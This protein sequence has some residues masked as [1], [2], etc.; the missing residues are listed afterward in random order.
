MLEFL[1]HMQLPADSAI[2]RLSLFW[3]TAH[4]T[5]ADSVGP[6]YVKRVQHRSLAKLTGQIV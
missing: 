1:R 6:L 5:F 2:W 4:T 3:V